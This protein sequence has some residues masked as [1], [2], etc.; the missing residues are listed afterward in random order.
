MRLR[1]LKHAAEGESK[2]SWTVNLQCHDYISVGGMVV[3]VS[4]Q[5]PEKFKRHYS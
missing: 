3:H 5:V 1:K 2:E 4:D